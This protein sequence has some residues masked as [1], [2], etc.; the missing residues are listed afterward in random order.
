MFGAEA[1]DRIMA[2]KAEFRCQKED[3]P[4]TPVFARADAGRCRLADLRQ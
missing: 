1:L 4:T 3:R 2:R